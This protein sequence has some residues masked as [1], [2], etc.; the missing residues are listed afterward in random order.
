[1]IRDDLSDLSEFSDVRIAERI[2]VG[3]S[4]CELSGLCSGLGLGFGKVGSV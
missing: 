4:G 1:V 3:Y 2:C